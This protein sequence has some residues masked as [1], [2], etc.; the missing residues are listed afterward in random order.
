M[1]IDLQRIFFIFAAA[2]AALFALLCL[3][4]RVRLPK[5]LQTAADVLRYAC[6]QVFLSLAFFAVYVL[7][8]KNGS[9]ARPADIGVAMLPFSAAVYFAAWRFSALSPKRYSLLYPLAYSL[10]LLFRFFAFSAD[11]GIKFFGYV[12][13]NPVYGFIGSSLLNGKLKYLAAVSAL[14]PFVTAAVGYGLGTKG[15]DK[16]GKM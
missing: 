11:G 5:A 4:K 13:L 1:L 15:I 6:I 8:V 12:L 3:L 7:Y 16:R 9:A 10:F 14:L 2:D